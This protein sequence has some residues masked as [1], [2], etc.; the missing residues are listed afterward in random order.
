M[1]TAAKSPQV[2][3]S[4]PEATF[5]SE[6]RYSIGCDPLVRVGPLAPL[7]KGEYE[8]TIQVRGIRKAKALATLLV[9]VKAFG[10][11]RIHIR[12]RVGSATIKPLPGPLSPRTIVSLYR[13]GL[14][15]NRLY[16]FTAAKTVF[17]SAFVYPVFKARVVQFF[18][19]DLSDF[20]S[21]YNNI[22]AFVF[23]S[24]LRNA[25]GRTPI[26]FST[27]LIKK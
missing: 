15:S 13:T 5:H 19:D 18:N 7:N 26:Q 3:L 6:L 17:G 4:P 2:G 25:I 23:R 10:N 12:V 22:A 14:Q 21:N 16:Q 1:K 11:I 27:A 20:Y 8:V 24:V 9:P